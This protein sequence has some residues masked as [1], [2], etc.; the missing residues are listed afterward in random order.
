MTAFD[1]ITPAMF[2]ED[3][4]RD[5]GNSERRK[6][7]LL[8]VL[9]DEDTVEGTIEYLNHVLAAMDNDA[10]SL[11]SGDLEDGCA[12]RCYGDFIEDQ[13]ALIFDRFLATLYVKTAPEALRPDLVWLKD[14]L[15]SYV[16]AQM[17]AQGIEPRD[18]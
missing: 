13:D 12:A 18:V 2:I 11:S 16:L 10:G 8:F 7:V 14:V 3:E 15:E 9:N 4:L 1:K 17:I 6:A 5:D